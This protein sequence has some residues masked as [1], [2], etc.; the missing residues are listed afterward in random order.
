MSDIVG[1]IRNVGRDYDFHENALIYEAADEI[2]RLT[3]AFLQ[4]IRV[5]NECNT[6]CAAGSPC[7]CAVEHQMWLEKE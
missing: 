6:V 1:R 5:V 2:E 7:L 3:E 4:F